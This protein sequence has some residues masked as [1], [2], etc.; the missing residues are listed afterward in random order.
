MCSIPAHECKKNEFILHVLLLIKEFHNF[1]I[2]VNVDL[3]LFTALLF[4]LIHVLN[5]YY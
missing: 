2:S 1:A 4:S 3:A 5:N